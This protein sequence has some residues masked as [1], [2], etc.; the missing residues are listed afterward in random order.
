[1]EGNGLAPLERSGGKGGG[2]GAVQTMQALVLGCCT[3]CEQI[4]KTL[5]KMRTKKVPVI[6]LEFVISTPLIQ[7]LIDQSPRDLS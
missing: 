5:K 3:D 4:K 2:R 7:L 6:N 1:M